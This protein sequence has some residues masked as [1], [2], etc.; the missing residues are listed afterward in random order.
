MIKSQIEQR[1]EQLGWT[2]YKLAKQ[3]ASLKAARNGEEPSA[4]TRYHTAIGKALDNPI[5][6]K[7]ETIQEIVEALGGTLQITWNN[8][9]GMK[10][11]KKTTGEQLYL[12][13]FFDYECVRVKVSDSL[14][15]AI[16][17]LLL[18]HNKNKRAEIWYLSE[19]IWTSEDIQIST[20]QGYK[21]VAEA[22]ELP[23]SW[24]TYAG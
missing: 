24:L 11:L 18:G 19:C 8:L 6:S 2:L 7:L 21:V 14:S 4:A 17:E 12:V 23:N 10:S 9:P 3:V 1:L 22:D 13:K 15:G 5:R 16:S 20:N